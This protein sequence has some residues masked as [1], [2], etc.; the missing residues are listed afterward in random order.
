[1]HLFSSFFL[2]SLFFLLF[3][4]HIDVL[5]LFSKNWTKKKSPSSNSV[6]L[7]TCIE[8]RVKKEGFHNE[9]SFNSSPLR[10]VGQYMTIEGGPRCLVNPSK[11]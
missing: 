4:F 8:E 7:S 9:L 3:S 5:V 6:G 11:R 2:L 10:L 1:M